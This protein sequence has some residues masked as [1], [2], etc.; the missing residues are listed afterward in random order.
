MLPCSENFSAASFSLTCA[1]F[2]R[3]ISLQL[4]LRGGARGGLG[5]YSPPSEHASPPSEGEK[6]FFSEIFIDL[7]NISFFSKAFLVKRKFFL[8]I[9]FIEP[10]VIKKLEWLWA[11]LKIACLVRDVGTTVT[12]HFF[13][14]CTLTSKRLGQKASLFLANKWRGHGGVWGANRSP[15]LPRW[16]STFP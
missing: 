13:K 16:C 3:R 8:D 6:R 10:L 15:L 4:V 14:L 9:S 12:R 5:G 1:A 11:I 2:S 7:P